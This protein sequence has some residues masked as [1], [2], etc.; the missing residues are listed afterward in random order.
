MTKIKLN[1][2]IPIIDESGKV[3]I[4]G[5]NVGSALAQQMLLSGSNEET[6]IYKIFDWALT[7]GK[8]D[9]IDLNEGDAKMLRKWIVDNKELFILI[10]GPALRALDA[11]DFKRVKKIA[12]K[13]E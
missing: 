3:T 6:E 11:L 9:R 13:A 8:G 7:L 1:L 5:R 12:G 4:P 10:K 2:R